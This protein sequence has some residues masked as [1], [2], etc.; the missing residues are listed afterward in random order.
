M[1]GPQTSPGGLMK[2]R[3]RA[4]W[5]REILVH[6]IGDEWSLSPAPSKKGEWVFSLP[7]GWEY[8][9]AGRNPARGLV[10]P[11]LLTGL[12]L[13]AGGGGISLPSLPVVEILLHG[14]GEKVRALRSFLHPSPLLG[15]CGVLGEG[16][17]EKGGFRLRIL[18]SGRTFLV[19]ETEKGPLYRRV[20]PYPAGS[21]QEISIPELGAVAVKDGKGRPLA[22][23]RIRLLHEKGRPFRDGSPVFLDEGYTDLQGRAAFPSADLE[24]RRVEA[25]RLGYAPARARA[26]GGGC[27]LVLER[28]PPFQVEI[29][30]ERMRG[31][32]TRPLPL[33]GK[34]RIREG[35]LLLQER[36]SFFYLVTSGGLVLSGPLG[37]ERRVAPRPAHKVRF[38]VEPP[39]GAAR[40]FAGLPYAEAQTRGNPVLS[41]FR[42]LVSGKPLGREARGSAL[43]LGGVYLDSRD[44]YP[45]TWAPP[46]IT[47]LPGEV[48][49][50][51]ATGSPARVRVLGLDGKPAGGILVS[52]YLHMG[53]EAHR[54]LVSGARSGLP[55]CYEWGRMLT[56]EKGLVRQIVPKGSRLFVM[57][58]EPGAA[59]VWV[60]ALPGRVTPLRMAAPAWLVIHGAG[61]YVTFTWPGEAGRLAP[62]FRLMGLP[63]QAWSHGYPEEGILAGPLPP[64]R[65][66]VRD[67]RRGPGK[68]VLLE[69]GKVS[70]V[71]FP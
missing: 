1:S 13:P 22:G 9:L 60:E 48:V 57:V 23:V 31:G 36:K 7:A 24:K 21:R 65:L 41:L 26:E 54:R 67:G 33:K 29:P 28:K 71:R 19:L 70:H 50:P 61:F 32:V 2:L 8:A 53:K 51:K 17:L 15:A 25:F 59:P 6:R 42:V 3:L 30:L 52:Y 62:G 40:F 58:R 49:F 68:V 64:G 66:L 56:G 10:S 38:R 14:R 39:G 37:G 20:G 34:C 43:I 12:A 69:G 47:R 11:I 4:P 63:L 55:Y 16:A 45:V 18:P 27:T 35:R 5:A 46:E 44:S